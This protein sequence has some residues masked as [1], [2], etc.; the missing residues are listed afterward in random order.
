MVRKGNE[1]LLANHPY[2]HQVLIW[3]KQNSK[4]KNFRKLLKT[5]RSENYDLVINLQRFLSTG[6]LTA[7][8]NAETKIGFRKNPMSLFF[9][10]KLPHELN[11]T[12]EVERNLSL[13]QH[14]TD[15]SFEM[16]KLHPSIQNFQKTSELLSN[17]NI[18]PQK[19]ITIAPT[20]VW[21][22]KQLPIKNGK[23]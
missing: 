1:S 21:F 4:Y 14:L 16:P 10:K 17:L 6:V 2:L 23:R 8:S 13:I 5:I 22:T 18:N 3:D 15:D 19:F 11:G 9:N 12:H 20:S 7:F